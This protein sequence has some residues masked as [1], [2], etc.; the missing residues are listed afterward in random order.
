M[1][2]VKYT[3]SIG[4]VLDEYLVFFKVITDQNNDVEFKKFRKNSLYFLVKLNKDKSRTHKSF[5]EFLEIN[6]DDIIIG[7]YDKL[8]SI[9]KL[10][11]EFLEANTLKL[12][13]Q[14]RFNISEYECKTMT[15][16]E[17]LKHLFKY[18]LLTVARKKLIFNSIKN[19]V[20][21]Y[22]SRN[23]INQ[24][25]GISHNMGVNLDHYFSQNSYPLFGISFFNFIPS[26][27]TCNSTFKNKTDI[28]A[29]SNS[30]NGVNKRLFIHPHKDDLDCAEFTLNLNYKHDNFK[31][32]YFLFE[33]HFEIGYQ[34]SN[35][36]GFDQDD[37]NRFDNSAKLFKIN[38]IYN[39][40]KDV[41]QR[42]LIDY[43]VYKE[44]EVLKSIQKTFPMLNLDNK[45]LGVSTSK[46]DWLYQPFGKLKY[47]IITS[48]KREGVDSNT[49]FRTVF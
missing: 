48:L 47:D 21:P 31:A 11:K 34:L 25:E 8:E 41:V 43:Y 26:C 18:E 4:N 37:F 44:G 22:C 29:V 17:V 49:D 24:I 14:I 16:K 20:C 7:T 27:Q 39:A 3:E 32:E 36:L 33:E 5:F 46:E 30:R 42:T 15:I 2:N 35:R 9:N 40:H 28:S 23:F 13:S 12:N 1:N 19:K 38:E 45:I 10:F 6:L